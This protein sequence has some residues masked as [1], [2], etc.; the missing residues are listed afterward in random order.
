MQVLPAR[1]CM[2]HGI[3]PSAEVGHSTASRR[4]WHTPP[5]NREKILLLIV[6][7]EQILSSQLHV[8][9]VIKFAIPKLLHHQSCPF[10]Y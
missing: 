10:Q 6:K 4:P 9:Q 5:S 7:P 2:E 1:C 8:Q 3:R